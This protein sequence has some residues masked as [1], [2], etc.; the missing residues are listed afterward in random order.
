MS[1]ATNYEIANASGAAVRSDLNDVFAAIVS[2]NAGTIE[3]VPS[4]TGTNPASYA[5]M[6]WADTGGSQHSPPNSV[7]AN[8][9]RMRNGANTGWIHIGDLD[10]IGLNIVAHKF[11]NVTAYVHATSANLNT[12]TGV[13]STLTAAELNTLDGVNSTLTASELNILDGVT[14]TATELNI[15]D[16]VTSTA[17][18]L[19]ILDGVTATTTQLN[20]LDGVTSSTADLNA[21]SSLVTNVGKVRQVRFTYISTLDGNQTVS[22][23]AGSAITAIYGF[24]FEEGFKVNPIYS[25]D[26]S[27]SSQTFVVDRFNS[28]DGSQTITVD[29]LGA[30]E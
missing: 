15:L 8:K 29:I 24:S 21:V 30:V 27:A 23:P 20:I 22:L 12:L 14:S 16:G 18:E 26:F 5:Y 1:Q 6:L 19:N 2:Q 25:H 4:P 17:T 28:E 3:P 13:N 11:P 10:Q 7:A 9:L